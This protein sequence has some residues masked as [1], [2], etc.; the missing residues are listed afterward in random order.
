M[1]DELKAFIQSNPDSRELKRAT[2]VEMYLQGYKHREIQSILGVSS[3]FI[4]QWTQFYQNL[5]VEGLKLA[6]QGSK[7]YLDADQRQAIV[8]WLQSKAAWN[9]VELQNYIQDE[10]NL[11]FKSKQSYYAL[12]QEAGISWKKTQKRNPKADPA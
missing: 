3:S 6:H 10:Y 9:L 5:G 4:S 11:V 12:F 2:A 8:R 1:T 7:G